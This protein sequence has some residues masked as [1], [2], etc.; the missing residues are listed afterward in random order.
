MEALPLNEADP[1]QGSVVQDFMVD[2]MTAR[3]LA[4]AFEETLKDE[5]DAMEHELAMEE[6]RKPKVQLAE[7]Q[8]HDLPSTATSPSAP[9]QLHAVKLPPGASQFERDVTDLIMGLSKAASGD[10]KFMAT[11]MGGTV[12]TIK[13][14]IETDMMVKVL[15]A[16]KSNQ[17]ELDKLGAVVTKCSTTRDA[18]LTDAAK[19][20]T[21]YTT[22]SPLHKDC[23]KSE[24][25]LYN[26]AVTCHQEWKAAKGLMKAECDGFAQTS[27]ELGSTTTN[28]GI[29]KKAVGEDVETYVYRL[30]ATF[31]G[32]ADFKGGYKDKFDIAKGKCDKATKDFN[33]K[34]AECKKL[35]KD[36]GAKRDTCNSIQEEMD[37]AACKA[38]LEIK[39]TCETYAE[40][41][42]VTV[43]A[44]SDAEKLIRPEE[45]DRKAEWRGLRRMLCL[46]DAFVD[47]KVTDAEVTVCQNKDHKPEANEKLSLKYFTI[48]DMEKCDVPNKYPGSVE[49][50]KAEFEGL[51]TNA[52]GNLDVLECAGVTAISTIPA[53]GS[54]AACK[55]ER[56]T[57][58][59]PYTPG[60][61]VKCT[62]CTTVYR[63]TDKISCP[64]GSKLFAPQSRGTG[65]PFFH[66]QVLC[67]LQTG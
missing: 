54:P 64:T 13:T 59:G 65:T 9:V 10:A 47:G 49:Y 61:L 30:H 40:C 51:P 37:E 63:S 66:P 11:P 56:I 15:A 44:Y 26:Q 6:Q 22:K 42:E 12:K 45:V 38:T 7:V 19:F 46:M 8:P 32:G 1:K 43:K 5:H 35:D 53:T 31:C 27:K 58:N 62:G 52:K 17:E 29:A 48:P 34:D 57:L 2:G 4:K 55:C 16:H 60:A 18:S 14:L 33:D 36:W 20:T 28:E 21:T 25:D 39:D 67:V 3:Q 41:H 50:V 24:A 23:R